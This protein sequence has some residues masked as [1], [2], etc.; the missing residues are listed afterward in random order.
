MYVCQKGKKEKKQ[1]QQQEAINHIYI[2]VLGRKK[3]KNKTTHVFFIHLMMQTNLHGINVHGEVF[4]HC[5]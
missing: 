2:T 5:I 1:E 4:T 3:K